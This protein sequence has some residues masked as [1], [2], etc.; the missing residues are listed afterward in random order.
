M[1]RWKVGWRNDGGEFGREHFNLN[2]NRERHCPYE[3]DG[4]SAPRSSSL[5]PSIET[6]TGA[7]REVNGFLM[8]SLLSTA[9]TRD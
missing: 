5:S 4:S 7:R 9:E 6:E 8:T 2:C 3:A 1:G